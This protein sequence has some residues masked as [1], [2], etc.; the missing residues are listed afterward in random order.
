M[1][2]ALETAI[3][4]LLAAAMVVMAWIGIVTLICAPFV[5]VIGGIVWI[6][7]IVSG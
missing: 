4:F 3:A 5:V 6:V 1:G 2:E 7:K